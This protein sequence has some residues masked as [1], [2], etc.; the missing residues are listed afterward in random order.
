MAENPEFTSVVTGNTTINTNGLTIVGGPSI[1]N[2]GINAGSLTITNVAPGVNGTDAVNVDQLTAVSNVANAGWNLNTAAVGSGVAMGSGLYNVAPGSTMQI[3][4]GN[5]IITTQNNGNV[6]VALNPNLTGIT[7]LAITGGPTLNSGGI[8]MNNTTIT[9]LAAG[10]NPTDA[11]NVSQLTNAIGSVNISFAGNSGGLVTRNNGQTLTIQGGGTTSGTYSGNNIR[12]VT[13]PA[14]GAINLQIADSPQFGNVVVNAG[15]T[16]QITGVT[17]GTISSTSTD[18]VNG[19]QLFALGSSTSTGFG[20]GS[21]FNPVT[22]Q[23]NVSL[24]VGTNTYNNVQDALQAVNNTASAGWNVTTGATGTGI[25][26]GSSVANVAPGSTA[27][28]NAGNNM[29]VTQSGTGVTYSVNPNLTGLSSISVTNGP[30]INDNGITM[31]QGDI[32]NMNNNRIT[33][34]APGINP[35]DAV[36]LSQL[37][38]GMTNILNQANTYTD[39]KFNEL[40]FDL[41]N[42]NRDAEGAT[43]SAMAMSQVPQAFEPGMGIV[44]F[45]VSTWQGEEAFAVGVSKASD[46]GR[47]IIKATGTYNTRKKGGAAV[48]VGIQF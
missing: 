4:A 39:N 47:V 36:N 8:N 31:S 18:A 38:S 22:G 21:T 24:T 37:N 11:V 13:D 45:G 27:T 19:S 14:N 23:V 3:I 28:F 9:N 12:T 33:N 34:V 20:G 43:A 29:V 25:A 1:T 41:R 10:V 5:N 17:A 26:N 6:E 35:T 7:S 32:L 42:F 44:G 40:A 16:G 46:N 15:G 2:T 30:T 48:G